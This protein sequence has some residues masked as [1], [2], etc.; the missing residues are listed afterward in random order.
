MGSISSSPG[1]D[2]SLKGVFLEV[3][4]LHILLCVYLL[5]KGVIKMVL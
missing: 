1:S 2:Y 4:H 3:F 5:L